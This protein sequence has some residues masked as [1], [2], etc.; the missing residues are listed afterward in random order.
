MVLG[1]HLSRSLT[2]VSLPCQMRGFYAPACRWGKN[3]SKSSEAT[4]GS[5]RAETTPQVSHQ[6]RK[7][8]S[9][10]F[11]NIRKVVRNV[12]KHSKNSVKRLKIFENIRIFCRPLRKWSRDKFV[13]RCSWLV[14]RRRINECPGACAFERAGASRYPDGSGS[15]LCS[16]IGIFATLRNRDFRY[17]FSLRKWLNFH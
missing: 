10:I 16:E 2:P 13:A 15:S 3:T 1:E 17:R 9:K 6:M 7:L 11:E 14:T 4:S 12:W 5:R 8:R